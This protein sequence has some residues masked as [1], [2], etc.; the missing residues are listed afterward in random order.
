MEIKLCNYQLCKGT[1]QSAGSSRRAVKQVQNQ[2]NEK[3]L[4]AH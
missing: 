3:G 2:V 4:E 1:F